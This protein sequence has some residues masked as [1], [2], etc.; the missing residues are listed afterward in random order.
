MGHQDWSAY[1]Q[2]LARELQQAGCLEPD[3]LEEAFFHVPRHMFIDQYLESGREGDV[4]VSNLHPP[5]D[6]HL[7]AIYSNMT[8]LV[9]RA[10]HEFIASQPEIIFAMLQDLASE[11]GDR[12]LEIGT[13]TGWNTGLLAYRAARDDLVYSMD[14]Q[15]NLVESA[16]LH[17]DSAGFPGVH[18]RAGDGGHGWPEAAPFD[19]IIV[20]VG[21]HD[22]PPHWVEQLADGGLLLVPLS[23]RGIG[24]P[25]LKLRKCGDQVAGRYMHWSW[26]Q[27]GCGDYAPSAA[28]DW[29]P[30]IEGI[31]R[32]AHREISLLEPVEQDFLFFLYLS[33]LRFVSGARCTPLGYTLVDTESDSGFLV[34]F[35]KPAIYAGADAEAAERFVAKQE[36][37]I[38]MGRPR[39]TDYRVV[40]GNGDHQHANGVTWVDQRPSTRLILSLAG[41]VD[42]EP[43]SHQP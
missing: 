7:R 25:V 12:V 10:P 8:L 5:K 39:V 41:E 26:F 33:G 32:D 20:T 36:E 1:A 38:G 23:T 9:R 22:I 16:R 19:R 30:V 14:I 40:V 13:G 18:L 37:W 34:S 21:F 42:D 24:E 28:T 17:L 3:W 6:S 29:D 2:E 35:D 15:S 11:P 27:P 31:L 43:D 4:L